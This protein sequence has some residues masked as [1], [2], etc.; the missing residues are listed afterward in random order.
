MTTDM[1][2][3][4]HLTSIERFVLEVELK[5]QARDIPA[6]RHQLSRPDSGGMDWPVFREIL[7][8]CS[9]LRMVTFKFITSLKTEHITTVVKDTLLKPRGIVEEE[10]AEWDERGMLQVCRYRTFLSIPIDN[11]YSRN[12]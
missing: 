8:R 2:P 3:A 9:S 12:Q 7:R 6:V 1:L 4:V 10:L 5:G 11:E